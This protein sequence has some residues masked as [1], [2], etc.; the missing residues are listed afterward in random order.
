MHTIPLT[1]NNTS[2]TTHL[3]LD[4]YFSAATTTGLVKDT[5]EDRFGYA[6]TGD[7]VRLCIA[8]GHWG[9]GAGNQLL[10]GDDYFV[11]MRA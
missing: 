10:V 9:S 8:D 7:V 6:A 2:T 3:R 1:T 5:N 11:S 4:G